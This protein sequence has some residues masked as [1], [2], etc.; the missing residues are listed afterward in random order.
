[1]V[2]NDDTS[3]SDGATSRPPL[4]FISHRHQD[5][6]LADVVAS[7][8]KGSSGGR[9]EVFQSSDAGASGPHSGGNLTDQLREALWKAGLVILLYTRHDADWS[10][11]MFECGLALQPD[12][13]DT[14]L[15]VFTCG[16]S[17]PPQFQGRVM[18]KVK[19]RADV[20]RFTNDFLTEPD[21]FPDF[22]EAV[23]PGF[24]PND[25]NVVEATDRLYK[26]IEAIPLPEE[27]RVED[28][29]AYPFLQLEITP[30][31]A[32]RLA[33]ETTQV[34]RLR[35]TRDV[36]LGA[37]ITDSDS[38]G[39]RIFGRREVDPDATLGSLIRG[40]CDTFGDKSPPWLEALVSQVMK[41]IQW[42]WPDLG[43][44]L[45][46]SIDN[47]DST[48]YGPVVT[49]IRRWPSKRMQFDISFNPFGL[50]EDGRH[51]KVGIPDEASAPQAAGAPAKRVD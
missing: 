23:A 8:L 27:E 35:G 4:V 44:E 32:V 28:W 16:D 43:W 41:G 49:R 47:R 48:L 29:P 15:K 13:P 30:E 5:K 26:G 39:A 11:C 22:H 2:T 31:S 1:M 40:W 38:E 50:T 14:R 33:E 7:F 20:Q 46:R 17:G 36:L 19:E 45:M 34:D 18:V 37:R 21:F 42:E 24:L 6:P 10:W 12:T 51:V 25:A 9:V 3:P